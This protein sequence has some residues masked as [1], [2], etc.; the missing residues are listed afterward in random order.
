[1]AKTNYRQ[2]SAYWQVQYAH[3][4]FLQHCNVPFGVQVV[5]LSFF[6]MIIKI[7]LIANFKIA[8]DV[9]IL[10]ME[11]RGDNSEL[12]CISICDTSSYMHLIAHS[13]LANQQTIQQNHQQT[14]NKLANHQSVIV[15][16]AK[17]SIYTVSVELR[18]L[19]CLRF[20]IFLSIV[21]LITI[22]LFI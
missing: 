18:Q 10:V 20:N 5:K 1:M 8:P 7:H 6:Y 15:Y 17:C 2:T 3:V 14:I 11:Y 13:K 12:V 4:G 19:P 16:F 9:L 22:Q 21:V